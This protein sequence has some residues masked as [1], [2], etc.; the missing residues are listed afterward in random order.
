MRRL[1]MTVAFSLACVVAFADTIT[2]KDGRV[3]EGKVEKETDTELK[4]RTQKGSFTV[5]KDQVEKIERGETSF[6]VL[7]AKLTVLTPEDPKGYVDLGEW[8]ITNKASDDQTIKRLINIGM[9]LD[10]TLCARGNALL[11][12]SEAAK[13]D[14]AEAA[15]YYLKSF[16]ADWSDKTVKDKLLKYKDALAERNRRLLE[17]LRDAI[18]L[19]IDARF[20]DAVPALT[21]VKNAPCADMIG[22]HC[23]GYSTIDALI[24]DLRTRIP[25]KTCKNLGVET[26]KVCG[27]KVTLT[28]TDCKG[29]GKKEIK[30]G[31]K[32]IRTETCRSCVKG[33]KTCAK[34]QRGKVTCHTCRGQVPAPTGTAVDKGG[35]MN[36]RKSI[37]N[38]LSGVLPIEEQ[39]GPKLPKLGT[40]SYDDSYLDDGKTVYHDGKWVSPSEKPD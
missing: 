20:A 31:T 36:F 15:D 12:D 29:T 18:T 28:C 21:S 13:G 25:C 9:G 37:E 17:K 38:R 35:L 8:C 6:E 23:A 5:P 1:L 22:R 2:M 7:E 27:G 39:I 14:R 4:I 3:F 16:T 19:A 34:C 40:Q 32:V 30:Q 24:N 10:P 26:C 33:K 11:G